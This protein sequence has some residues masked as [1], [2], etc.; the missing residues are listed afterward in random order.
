MPRGRR[1]T[2]LPELGELELRAARA[3]LEAALRDCLEHPDPQARAN[4]YMAY[5][6]ERPSTSPRG[7]DTLP[8]TDPQR[9]DHN[10]SGG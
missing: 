1:T 2:I 3:E 6:L 7:C 8:A 9:E 5:W 10:G 4:E